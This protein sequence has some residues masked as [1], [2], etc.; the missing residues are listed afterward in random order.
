MEIKDIINI[1][2]I[3]LSPIIAVVVTIFLQNRSDKKKEK[4]AIIKSLL[5]TGHYLYSD[6]IIRS[7][8]LIDIA[9]KDDKDVRAKWK[10]LF[11]RPFS[12]CL[13][14]PGF[15]CRSATKNLPAPRSGVQAGFCQIL[16][17]G[18]FR[19]FRFQTVFLPHRAKFPADRPCEATGQAAARTQ[20]QSSTCSWSV[21]TTITPLMTFTLP[22]DGQFGISWNSC[23]SRMAR[24]S[25]WLHCSNFKPNRYIKSFR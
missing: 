19:G 1:V 23:V 11:F 13:R 8:N 2:A 25:S 6:E 14:T 16:F 17:W 10:L 5:S 7:Y 9:F 21:L 15:I 18:R 4:I 22:V 20:G 3:V 24:Y 12:R